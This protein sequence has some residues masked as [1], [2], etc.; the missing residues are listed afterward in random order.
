MNKANF[1]TQAW[2]SRL[3]LWNFTLTVDNLDDIFFFL[4]AC[5][6]FDIWALRISTTHPLCEDGADK[7][8]SV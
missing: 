5:N 6:T 2:N 8:G 3:K 1:Q 7:D 4:I